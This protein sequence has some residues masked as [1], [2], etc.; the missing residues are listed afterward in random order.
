LLRQE[1]FYTKYFFFPI[2]I[3]QEARKLQI[4]ISKQKDA[5]P[6]VF[7]RLRGLDSNQLPPGYEPD[8][9]PLLYPAT[10][11]TSGYCITH[12]KTSQG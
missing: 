1:A 9:L 8:E 2:I 12:R 10:G 5:L 3:I 6:G 11:R 4:D 7:L